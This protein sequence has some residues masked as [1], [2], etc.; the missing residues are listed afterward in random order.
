M[1]WST[2]FQPINSWDN[3]SLA[4]ILGMLIVDTVL[5]LLLALYV[6]Q[7]RPGEFGIPQPWYFPVLP[8]YWRGNEIDGKCQLQSAVWAI[9][10]QFT[11]KELSCERVQPYLTTES[12]VPDV[13]VSSL[14]D[15]RYSSNHTC[16][17]SRCSVPSSFFWNSF[18]SNAKDHVRDQ[19]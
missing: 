14:S 7:V 6:E 9:R 2:V 17:T 15:R 16:D 18:S 11:I 12:P 8:S 13:L 10:V 1:Q 19:L 5:Y 4:A 3:I